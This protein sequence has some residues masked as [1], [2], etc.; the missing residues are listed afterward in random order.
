MVIKKTDLEEDNKFPIEISDY[1]FS[2]LSS[3]EKIKVEDIMNR[4]LGD[5]NLEDY[6]K[7]AVNQIRTEIAFEKQKSFK[8]MPVVREYRHIKEQEEKDF[9]E[10]IDL[11][12]DHKLQ[13]LQDDAIKE[14]MEKGE[15]L[16]RQEYIQAITPK[17][18]DFNKKLNEILDEVTEYKSK[19]LKE[20]LNETY[21]LVSTLVKWVIMRELKDDDNYLKSLLEKISIDLESS[22]KVLVK[23]DPEGFGEFPK[24]AELI[25]NHFSS[26]ENV[27]IEQS[28]VLG[29]RGLLVESE[30]SAINGSLQEQFS[31][32]DKLFEKVKVD[33]PE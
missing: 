23:V 26:C 8:I 17:I 20:K 10:R 13:D 33:V 24:A 16:G 28:T 19:V 25:E 11:E 12:V 6:T 2:K 27:R 32:I 15:E 3:L 14:G 5:D 30:K 9:Q 21:D 31:N 18:N 22:T 7:E 29:D 1:K 4:N